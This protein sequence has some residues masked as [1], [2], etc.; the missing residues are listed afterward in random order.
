MASL[1]NRLSMTLIKLAMARFLY[2]LVHL[3]VSQDK[4]IIHR[5]GIK[6]EVDLS[7]GID[8]YLFLF[9]NFQKY[10]VHS[11]YLSLAPD[12]V[13]LDVG[14]NIGAMTLQF[15]K[16]VPH[17]KVYS[18]EP[19]DYAFIKLQRNVTLNPE[20]VQRISME[21]KFVS[22]VSSAETDI[23]AYAS[24]KVNGKRYE[25]R[26]PIH[27]GIPQK[28]SEVLSITLDEFCSAR[29]LERIDLIKID[30]DGH[31]FDVLK[32]AQEIMV[33]Y[34]PQI[35]FE[36]GLYTMEERG[37]TFDDFC[38]LLLPIGYSLMNVNTGKIITRRNFLNEIPWKS[39]IDILAVPSA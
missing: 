22:N 20:L 2:R 18:F 29:N 33:K 7:E 21:R 9:G 8:L 4:R 13:V 10:I 16:Q 11:K 34:H 17:G 28:A 30:T 3:F 12:A 38:E 37:I 26:H 24:W 1:F 27:G 36:L 15:A 19:I 25:N 31:E 23:T 14:A 35:I 39:T 5:G 32:G 6:Y